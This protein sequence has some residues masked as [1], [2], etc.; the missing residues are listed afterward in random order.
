[1]SETDLT[2]SV[3]DYHEKRLGDQELKANELGR[4]VQTVERELQKVLERINH[5]ISPTMQK[6][7]EKQ[8]STE[9][10]IERLD[11]KLELAIIKI[12]TDLGEKITGLATEVG[13]QKQWFD[14]I[15]SVFI[16]GVVVVLVGAITLTVWNRVTED[17]HATNASSKRNATE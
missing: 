7:L 3:L 4:T 15:K 14:S 12:G 2:K 11:H 8:S 9:I 6:V 13:N 10:S 16:K 17:R 1:M 5:G